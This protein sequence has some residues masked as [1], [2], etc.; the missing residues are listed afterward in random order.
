[1]DCLVPTHKDIANITSLEIE[2]LLGKKPEQKSTYCISKDISPTQVATLAYKLQSGLTILPLLA[3]GSSVDRIALHDENLFTKLLRP[4]MTFA[5][6]SIKEKNETLSS[7]HLQEEIGKTIFSW[8]QEKGITPKVSLKNPTITFVVFATG[9]EYFIGVDVIGFKLCNRPYKLFQHTASLNGCV[10]YAIARYAGVS[11][12]SVVVDPFCGTGT[13]PIEIALFQQEKSCFHFENKFT[14]CNLN[15]FAAAFEKT[16]A[17]LKQSKEKKTEIYG[18]DTQLKMM[19]GA[20]QN[21][22]IAGVKDG[23]SFSKVNI[24]WV[25]AKFS[26]GEVDVIITQPPLISE[27]AQ[28]EKEVLKLYEELC[29]QAKYLLRQ[30]T[31]ILAVF[32]KQPE[33]IKAIINKQGM[34]FKKDV[35]IRIGDSSFTLVLSTT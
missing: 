17:K 32:V 6:R 33:K 7:M 1:M 2:E 34:L 24:D 13:I 28:N 18:F 11:K 3:K 12:K 21:A 19:K 27:R 5:V 30:K 25:D 16:A 26:A 20:Q 29:Q 22:K 9:K 14:G 23:V 15:V 35:D 8:I 31:G 4:E 10:A